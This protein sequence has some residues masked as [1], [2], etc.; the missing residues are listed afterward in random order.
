MFVTG[1]INFRVLVL[2]FS[3]LTRPFL[4]GYLSTTLPISHKLLGAVGSML[5]T[6]SPVVKHPNYF[7]SIPVSFV[8]L[9][10]IPLCF[11]NRSA[12]YFSIFSGM[13]ITIM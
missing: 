5:M 3:D 10:G 2:S 7:Y 9:G 4:S 6:R 8:A 11:Q 1:N 13:Q 12:R